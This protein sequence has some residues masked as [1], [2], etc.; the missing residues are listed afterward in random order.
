[1]LFAAGFGRGLGMVGRLQYA[2]TLIEQETAALRRT[3]IRRVLAFIHLS[4]LSHLNRA[5]SVHLDAQR[6]LAFAFLEER[7]PLLADNLRNRPGS[8]R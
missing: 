2:F 4:L 3:R 8:R 6:L 5:E 1:M 7:P